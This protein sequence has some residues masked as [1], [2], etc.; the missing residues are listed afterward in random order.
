MHEEDGGAF[1]NVKKEKIK[2]VDIAV[3]R[4]TRTG[5]L[6]NARPCRK[7]LDMMRNLN[8][9]K[10]FYSTGFGN[11]IK[12]EL[13][14]DM[15]SIQDSSSSKY[16][17]KMTSRGLNLN[18]NDQKYYQYLM[19]KHLPKVVKNNNL[20]DFINYFLNEWIKTLKFKLDYRF[21]KS[22]GKLFFEIYEKDIYSLYLRMEVI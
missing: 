2:K 19:D 11:E 3:V 13:V 10:V 4:L 8:V 20:Q 14:K 7:C 12:K 22:K 9:R 1:K 17:E 18:V 16:F 21:N 6:A 5:D 15:I